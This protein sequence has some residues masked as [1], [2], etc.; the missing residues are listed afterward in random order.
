LS[1]TCFEPEGSSLGRQLYI[2]V[3]Y[4]VYQYEHIL[5]HV[6]HTIPNLYIQLSSE[7]E[8]SGFKHVEDVKNQNIKLEKVHLVGL[9]CIRRNFVC[10]RPPLDVQ[11]G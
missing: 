1:S 8:P 7:D 4:S 6:N 11:L 3:W 9:Y 10:S 5:M 2:Q